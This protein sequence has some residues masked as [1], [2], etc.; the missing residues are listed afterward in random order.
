MRNVIDDPAN[1]QLQLIDLCADCGKWIA[2]QE[3]LAVSKNRNLKLPTLYP[4]PAS[5]EMRDI[6]PPMESNI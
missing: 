3:C 2:K 5:V 4:P 6:L 1:L